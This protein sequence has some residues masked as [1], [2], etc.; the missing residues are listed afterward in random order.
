MPFSDAINATE[1]AMLRRAA[2]RARIAEIDAQILE[3]ER[4]ILVLRIEKDLVQKRLDSYTYPVLTLPIEI[5]SKIFSQFLPLYPQC[6]PSTGLCSPTLLTHICSEWREIALATPALWRAIY[7]HFTKS[8][9]WGYADNGDSESDK[10]YRDEQKNN[11]LRLW[12]AISGSYPLSICINSDI[13]D[14]P[15]CLETLTLHRA[16]WEHLHAEWISGDTP[17]FLY[18]PMPLLCQLEVLFSA[19]RDMVTLGSAPLLRSAS[20]TCYSVFPIILP[21]TQLT[22]LKLR[23]YFWEFTPILR[24][25]VHLV[26]CE[27]TLFR[28]GPYYGP[29]LDIEIQSLQSFLLM[30]DDTEE[31]DGYASNPEFLTT[32]ILPTLHTLQIPDE[33]L[34]ADFIDTLISFISKSRC[35]LQRLYI[36]GKRTATRAAYRRALPSIPEVSFYR[37]STESVDDSNGEE[38]ESEEDASDAGG[39]D[40]ETE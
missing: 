36:T 21:W 18:D 22:S 37:L 3:V 16:R 29:G 17:P 20:V 12:M 6:P 4:S 5:T 15:Q 30:V 27:L 7:L 31:E 24:H 23:G 2:D 9:F 34:K 32:F 1:A 33:F 10:S 35:A 8:S 38:S 28:G 13:A 26:H 25:T 11:L 14:I 40:S 39:G 19:D